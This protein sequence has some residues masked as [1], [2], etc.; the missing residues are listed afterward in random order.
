MIFTSEKEFQ[1]LLCH[2]CYSTMALKLLP[3]LAT[4][5]T[6]AQGGNN[7]ERS[8]LLAA[9]TTFRVC[10]ASERTADAEYNEFRPMLTPFHR[11]L[12]LLCCLAIATI[13]E[14][15]PIVHSFVFF[16]P[17]PNILQLNHA[18]VLWAQL[19]LSRMPSD[20]IG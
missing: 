9:K 20:Q 8:T 18:G 13:E 19:W 7:N 15:Q 14:N 1:N 16:H 6:L 10:S 2:G 3:G 11:F 5:A 12:H 17:S 4:K